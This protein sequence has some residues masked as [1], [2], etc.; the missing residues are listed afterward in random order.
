MPN[1]LINLVTTY[2]NVNKYNLF[3]LSF[4]AFISFNIPGFAQS[5]FIINPGCNL[6]LDSKGEELIKY[7]NDNKLQLLQGGTN[8]TEFISVY[9]NPDQRLVDFGNGKQRNLDATLSNIFTGWTRCI[10]TGDV[11]VPTIQKPK[12]TKFGLRSHIYLNVLPQIGI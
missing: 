1:K 10:S 11:D 6:T 8:T 5:D 9:F 3:I 4:I 7:I 12:Q 2:K